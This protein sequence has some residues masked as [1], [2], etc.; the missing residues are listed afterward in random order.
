MLVDQ[1]Y[2]KFQSS[3]AGKKIVWV[4][5]PDLNKERSNITERASE[6]L[7]KKKKKL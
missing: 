7:K 2:Q 5:N 1:P 4:R 6:G 3:L